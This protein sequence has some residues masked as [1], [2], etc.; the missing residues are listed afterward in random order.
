MATKLL[1]LVNYINLSLS[2][3]HTHTDVVQPNTWVHIFLITIEGTAD[4]GL[5]LDTRKTATVNGDPLASKASWLCSFLIALVSLPSLL[6]FIQSNPVQS[7]SVCLFCC[8]LSSILTL[9]LHF[10]QSLFC[11]HT[12]SHIELKQLSNITD[13]ISLYAHKH[14]AHKVTQNFYKRCTK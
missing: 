14:W 12:S 7:L 2:L 11:P 10:V 5:I 9:H 3:P 13:Y 6:F 1:H 8:L 4:D